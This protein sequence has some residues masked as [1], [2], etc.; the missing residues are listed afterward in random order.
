[1]LAKDDKEGTLSR[2]KR[3]CILYRK[4][5]KTVLLW[6]KETARRV[7]DMAKFTSGKEARWEINKWEGK[8][9]SKEYFL[10]TLSRLL[11]PP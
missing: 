10:E 7:E 4:S 1:M 9:D 8:D 3:N 11:P 5:E 2:N 6:L